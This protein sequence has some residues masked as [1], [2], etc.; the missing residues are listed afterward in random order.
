MGDCPCAFD[1]TWCAVLDIFRGPPSL[2]GPD[3]QAFGELL[4]KAF[5]TMGLRH[6]DGTWKTEHKRLWQ[7]AKMRPLL[8]GD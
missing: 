1:T 2:L 8:P 5:G 4:L 3:T 7:A 6:Y